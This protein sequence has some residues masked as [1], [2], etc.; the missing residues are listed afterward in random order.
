MYNPDTTSTI[1]YEETAIPSSIQPDVEPTAEQGAE[2]LSLH[3]VVSAIGQNLA[4]L[5]KEKIELEE[6]A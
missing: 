1:S 3:E 4:S 6:A 2:R 5:R